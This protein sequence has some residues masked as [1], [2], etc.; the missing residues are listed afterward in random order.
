VHVIS[1]NHDSFNGLGYLSTIAQSKNV[2]YPIVWDSTGSTFSDYGTEAAMLP[3]MFVVDQSGVI[4]LRFDGGANPE[5]FPEE[6]DSIKV[7]IDSLLANPPQ[8]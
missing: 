6:L 4:R 8:N 7:T 5:I 1:L 3:S 2:T